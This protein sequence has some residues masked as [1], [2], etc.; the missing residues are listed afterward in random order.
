MHTSI[1]HHLQDSWVPSRLDLYFTPP[2]FNINSE[3][4]PQHQQ[5]R[6]H[7]EKVEEK[8]KGEVMYRFIHLHPNLHPH[9]PKKPTHWT[10]DHCRSSFSRRATS[11]SARCWFATWRRWS[12]CLASRGRSDLVV[13][14][15]LAL[16]HTVR[17]VFLVI[18]W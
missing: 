9:L 10:S 3:Q 5:D 11:A 14:P 8:L 18:C 1:W 2:R 12:F 13:V 15:P 7:L 17:Y 4:E 16:Y 6:H